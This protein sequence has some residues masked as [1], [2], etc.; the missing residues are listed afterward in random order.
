MR[1]KAT[2]LI[3]LAAILPCAAFGVPTG[4]VNFTAA[5]PGTTVAADPTLAGTVVEDRVIPYATQPGS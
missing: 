4:V 5:L 1:M 2:I 3:L